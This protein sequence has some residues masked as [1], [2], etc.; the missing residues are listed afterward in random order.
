[1]TIAWITGCFG[2][3]VNPLRAAVQ[4]SP[5]ALALLAVYGLYATQIWW[6]LRR[7]GSFRPLT[8]LLYPIPLLFFALLMLRSLLM[9]YVLRRVSWRGRRLDPKQN[10]S[11]S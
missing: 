5:G 6:M 2:A 7:I 10:G 9:T 1:M 4:F 3:F 11:R 8:A